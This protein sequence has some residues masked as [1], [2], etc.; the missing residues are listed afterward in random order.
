MQRT[1]F[2]GFLTGS[3]VAALALLFVPDAVVPVVEAQTITPP[4]PSTYS[5]GHLTV[6]TALDRSALNTTGPQ[7]RYAVVELGAD[8]DV[9]ADVPVHLSLVVDTSGSMSGEKLSDAKVAAAALVGDLEP[10]DSV[11]LVGFSEGAEVHQSRTTI[12]EQGSTLDGIWRLS[13]GGNTNMQ[14]GLHAG[15]AQLRHTERG[16]RR[17]VLLGDGHATV[18]A[19]DTVGLASIAAD[20]REL[21]IT[22]SALGLGLDFDLD[23]MAA[24]ADAGGGRYHYVESPG[25][26]AGMLADELREA[27]QLAAQGVTVQISPGAG[28]TVLDVFGYESWDGRATSSGWEALV[29]DMSGGSTRKVVAKLQIDP[30]LADDRLAQVYVTFQDPSTGESHAVNS[31]LWS[32]TTDDAEVLEAALDERAVALVGQV[33][34]GRAREQAAALRRKGQVEA[35]DGVLDTF[36]RELA[37]LSTTYKAPA[38]AKKSENLEATRR[39]WRGVEV[40]SRAEVSL[41]AQE[42][43]RALGYIE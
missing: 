43:L 2:R 9:D 6:R 32:L 29:G 4:Q 23:T 15:M 13:A 36:S 19:T 20:A 41:A 22:V 7:V 24:V 18:G 42:Q 38:L 25:A 10:G 12:F 39:T 8:T 28:V 34:E 27:D 16:S 30:T 3:G 11:S 33:H 17:L 1:A 35:A 14:A 26:L 31:G 40:G 37:S 5:E 21:G